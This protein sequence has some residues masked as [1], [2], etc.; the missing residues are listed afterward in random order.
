MSSSLF[1]L[2][3]VNV[4]EVP[5]KKEYAQSVD[6]DGIW[7]K[8]RVKCHFGFK[9]N[10]VTDNQVLVLGVLTTTASRNEITNLEDVLNL[11]N[12]ELPKDIPLKADKIKQR[13]M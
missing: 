12:G 5:V 9:K 3:P 13:K 11:V 1:R 2:S 10:H 8:K 6:K 4:A 7:L